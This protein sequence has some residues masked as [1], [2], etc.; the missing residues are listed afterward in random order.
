[1]STKEIRNIAIIAHV[2]HGKTT[3]VDAL[4]R[5]SQTRL[6]AEVAASNLIM[7]S[8]ELEKERGITIF[9]KNASVQWNGVTINIIDTPGHA[10]FGGEV[11]RV[12]TMADGCLLL[13]DAKEGPMPQ[14]RFVLK[15]ALD[16]KKRVVVV[17]NK[18]DK[19]DARIDYVLEKTFE[20]FI[21]LGADESAA[22]FPVVYASAKQGLAGAEA[23]LSKMTTIDPI[24]EAVMEHIPAPSGDPEKPF[25]FLATSLRSDSFRGRIAV[26]R[27]ENGRVKAGQPIV[28]IDRTGKPTT[29][30]VTAL[31]GFSG[32]DSIDIQEAEAGEII[33]IAGIPDV[34]I[35]E[36]IADPANPIALPLIDIEQPTLRMTFGVNTSPFAGKE[37]EFKTSR[38]IRARLMHELE[39]DMAL[40]VEDA[41]SGEWIVSG[42]G[43]L[44]LSILIE[45]LR[46]EGY[47]FQV[48][49]PQVI[50]REIDGKTHEPYERVFI[51][52]PEAHVGV[53]LEKLGARGGQVLDM[54]TNDGQTHLEFLIATR[55]LFGYRSE[56]QTD[57]RG[58]GLMNTLF[59]S[60]KPEVTVDRERSRGA[61]VVF[62]D[63]V[64]N[65]YGLTNA[66]DRGQLFVGPGIPVYRG[67]VVGENAR[68]GDLQL[69]VCKEKHLTNMRSKGDG[70]A[71]HFNVPR[72]M[73]LEDA[74][75][76]I[77]DTELV[78]VTPKTVR[79]R[80]ISL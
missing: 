9:S 21:E 33:A 50:T 6:K 10:D 78:E 37:G 49:R 17:I 76:F 61:L 36:T 69:N 45:R 52:V 11:E 12:L 23:D 16:L 30:R 60:Y 72:T 20:L 42:R 28:R 66:Q 46:R 44:H 7:D 59:D 67:Q 58:L 39:T 40:R 31:M 5:Q 41:P 18:I 47:E 13:V 14:T 62:E 63:G 57:T 1:M 48:M 71:V 15:R 75:E 68:Q 77:D 74:L 80:K 54:S 51:D 25:Q 73:D 8:N 3:L 53:V 32:L 19:S 43:E 2:D 79:I 65:L 70:S 27:I 55:A 64:T 4:L 22:F 24:F 38:Q 26:G 29:T 35:G 34:A 56:I